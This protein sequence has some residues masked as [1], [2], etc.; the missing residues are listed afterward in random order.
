M[1]DVASENYQKEFFPK[2]FSNWGA[3]GYAILGDE[4]YYGE[5]D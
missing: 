3:D 5:S 4:V 1:K 2:F